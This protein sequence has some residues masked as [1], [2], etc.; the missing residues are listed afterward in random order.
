[1]QLHTKN[2][3]EYFKIDF[4]P[5]NGW[6]D[7][8]RCEM[9]PSE[10]VDLHHIERRMK[11]VKKL[12]EVGN[13]IALCRSCHEKAHSNVYGYDKICLKTAH[14]NCIRLRK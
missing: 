5:S 6:H 14:D 3:F 7:Y 1:M 9:C 13:I 11:G 10:A 2:Y 12:D 8:I 4:D